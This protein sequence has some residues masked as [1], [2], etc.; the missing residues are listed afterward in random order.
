MYRIGGVSFYS[1]S[2]PKESLVNAF[3]KT[4]RHYYTRTT[5]SEIPKE[6]SDDDMFREMAENI[7]ETSPDMLA[8]AINQEAIYD[9]RM[10]YEQHWM[11]YLWTA[12]KFQSSIINIDC[13]GAYGLL[14]EGNPKC[15][16]EYHEF[17]SRING[18]SYLVIN[19]QSQIVND[20]NQRLV[21]SDRFINVIKSIFLDT[22]EH[23]GCVYIKYGP[24]MDTSGI[25]TLTRVLHLYL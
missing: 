13:T 16:Q 8:F 11:D 3:I 4:R 18:S 2:D 12:L 5:G 21:L 25:L 19:K 14:R 22:S 24:S 1:E 9:A 10:V 7:Y 23:N 15:L 20:D 6:L 17:L